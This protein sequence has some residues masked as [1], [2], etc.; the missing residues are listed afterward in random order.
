[1]P[2]RKYGI[3]APV[4]IA[5]LVLVFLVYRFYASLLQFA[6]QIPIA[7][8]II[9]GVVA[10]ILAPFAMIATT[11]NAPRASTKCPKCG[12][13]ANRGGDNFCRNCSERL[14]LPVLCGHCGLMMGEHDQYCGVCKATK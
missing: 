8:L 5:V 9:V 6:L 10:I 1:M 7:Y 13:A 4:A 14:Y 2:S 3:L 11:Q 12:W